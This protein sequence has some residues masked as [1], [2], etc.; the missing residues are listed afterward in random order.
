[1]GFEVFGFKCNLEHQTICRRFVCYKYSMMF[2]L[3]FHQK[4]NLWF[5]FSF[6]WK[7]ETKTITEKL[8]LL[9]LHLTL[10]KSPAVVP[11]HFGLW[12]V[13]GSKSY[14]PQTLEFI[15]IK[16]PLPVWLKSTSGLFP[17][18]KCELPLVHWEVLL[19]VQLFFP[20]FSQL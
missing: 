20:L 2:V 12:V 1:M 10:Q 11:L 16:F 19:V 4:S 3:F 13:D 8:N 5:K 14:S 17:V 9:F 7:S 15:F 6:Y 18:C